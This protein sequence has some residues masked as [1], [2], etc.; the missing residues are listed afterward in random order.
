MKT[1]FL[2]LLNMFGLLPDTSLWT[3]GDVFLYM[4]TA[5]FGM[6]AI[7]MLFKFVYGIMD[8]FSG[9]GL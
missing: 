2:D 4:V 1:A 6:V 9:G 7:S 8:R 5:L 3:V